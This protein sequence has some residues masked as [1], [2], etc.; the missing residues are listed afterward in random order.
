MAAYLEKRLAI[1][2]LFTYGVVLIGANGKGVADYPRVAG[3][4]TAAPTPAPTAPNAVAPTTAL[5][6]EYETLGG[7]G[8]DL[9]TVG[10]HFRF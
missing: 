2:R 6:L 7:E 8:G 5:R 4:A 1:Y 3:R 9:L 10:L